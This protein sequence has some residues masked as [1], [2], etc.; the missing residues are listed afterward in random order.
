MNKDE[1]VA[2]LEE[3][4][5]TVNVVEQASSEFAP[6]YIIS[7]DYEPG[8]KL[9]KGDTITITVSTGSDGAKVASFVPDVVGRTFEEAKQ[10]IK[11]GLALYSGA[12]GRI[13]RYRTQGL[14]N[15][16]GPGT[17]QRGNNQ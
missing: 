3:L 15:I 10:I 2:K 13:Q 1:V 12:E 8:T 9:R 16:S 4:G 5:F 7:Q 14:C 11:R 17:R 6:G